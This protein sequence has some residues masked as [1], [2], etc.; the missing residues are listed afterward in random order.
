MLALLTL[1]P[2]DFV[3][4]GGCGQEALLQELLPRLL[5]LHLDLRH[6]VARHKAQ[7]AAALASVKPIWIF[8][9]VDLVKGIVMKTLMYRDEILKD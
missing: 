2:T 9:S 6:H 7:A 1:S 5:V 3:H 8:I 4:G